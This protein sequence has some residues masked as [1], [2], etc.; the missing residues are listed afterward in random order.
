[1]WGE[2]DTHV[3]MP[4][5]IFT[6][7]VSVSWKGQG[8][9]P[10]QIESLETNTSPKLTAVNKLKLSWAATAFLVSCSNL[11]TNPNQLIN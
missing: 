4:A 3:W 10:V 5:E 7:T 2:A 8:S 9:G 1:M 11:L 6:L